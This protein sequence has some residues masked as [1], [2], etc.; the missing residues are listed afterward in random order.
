MQ[1]QAGKG[2]YNMIVDIVYAELVH[3]KPIDFSGFRS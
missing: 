3:Y 2:G 1:N